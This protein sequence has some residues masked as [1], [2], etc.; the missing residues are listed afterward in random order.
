MLVMKQALQACVQA[1]MCVHN[2]QY[3][4]AF[5]FVRVHMCCVVNLCQLCVAA[6]LTSDHCVMEPMWVFDCRNGAGGLS[7]S[8]DL[9][10]WLHSL[11]QQSATTDWQQV[12]RGATLFSGSLQVLEL[13]NNG[14]TRRS[15]CGKYVQITCLKCSYR[16]KTGCP[17]ICYW[18]SEVRFNKYL[19]Q[20]NWVKLK[21]VRTQ[22]SSKSTE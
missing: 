22:V 2:S 7:R 15:E 13:W 4:G 21:K 12:S 17:L 5:E 20:W 14:S 6:L 8:W 10:A 9:L 18:K 1:S 3:N 16:L 19:R 11:R